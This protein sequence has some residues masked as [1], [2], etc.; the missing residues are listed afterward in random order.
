[1]QSQ[2]PGPRAH[3]TKQWREA[4]SCCTE[5]SGLWSAGIKE[6]LGVFQA[7]RKQPPISSYDGLNGLDPCFV[8]RFH[9]SSLSG[10]LLDLQQQN[11]LVSRHEEFQEKQD[12]L[13][14]SGSKS[15]GGK[16]SALGQPANNLLRLRLLHCK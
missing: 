5:W 2:P 3:S 12:R 13:L 11:N 9:S 1:M 14:L 7:S 4:R 6:I 16:R 15:P 8:P 10:S